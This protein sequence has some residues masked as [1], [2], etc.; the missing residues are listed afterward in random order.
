MRFDFS[1]KRVLV[2]GG[3]RGIG[4]AVAKAFLTAGAIVAV[5][6]RSEQSVNAAIKAMGDN[7]R[8]ISAPGDIGAVAGCEAS[9]NLAIE[10]LGGLD[11]LIN[12]AG[13]AEAVPIEASDE[14]LWDNT[15][16]INLLGTFF[17]SRAA[18]RALR[19]S[20][21]NIVNVASDA[22]LMGVQN[23][24]VYCASK[25]G[26]V[27]LTRAMALEL[28][29]DVRVNC[30]CPGYV[31][32]DMVRRD[33]IEQEDNPQEAEEFLKSYAPLNRLAT[34]EEIAHS[35]LYLASPDARFATGTA[36]QID[37]GTTA[38]R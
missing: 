2:T 12:S 15:M 21:G 36:L 5:N 14:R 24:T 26:V 28:A 11:I 22:G 33:W 25:A 30:V 3:T 29:P 10:S 18:L 8:L 19:S 34:P 35:I 31:D 13:V 9:V 17:C 27:N 20:K 32:T 23:S 1:D 7:K 6:G 37:G 16:N 4:N 38:G